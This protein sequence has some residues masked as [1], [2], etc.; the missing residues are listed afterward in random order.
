MIKKKRHSRV[1]KR[2][3]QSYIIKGKGIKYERKTHYSFF[4][5]LKLIL[6]G[7]KLNFHP[8]L[9]NECC[10]IL[11]K[12]LKLMTDKQLSIIEIPYNR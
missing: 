11:K 10:I 1:R 2:I 5:L 12:I 6:M 4:F 7:I 8:N 3:K 9:I